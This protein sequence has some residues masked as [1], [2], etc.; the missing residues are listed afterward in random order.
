MV[1]EELGLGYA[2]AFH[3]D[4]AAHGVACL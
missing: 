2:Y 4:K 1:K 3:K